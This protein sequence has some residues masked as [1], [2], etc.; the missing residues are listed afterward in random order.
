MYQRYVTFL[1]I[2]SFMALKNRGQPVQEP[3][4]SASDMYNVDGVPPTP[5]A[6]TVANVTGIMTGIAS[7]A[8]MATTDTCAM[9]RCVDGDHARTIVA[10]VPMAMKRAAPLVA[11]LTEAT[12]V[13][14]TGTPRHEAIAFEEEEDSPDSKLKTHA[15]GVLR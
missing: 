15:T 2:A 1:D 7:V 14:L 12:V 3:C 6:Q 8:A 11:H 13:S 5:N 10:S 4:K 9:T